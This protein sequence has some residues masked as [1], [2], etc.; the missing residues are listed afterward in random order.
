MDTEDIDNLFRAGLGDHASP[1][2]G[3]L[4]ARLQAKTAADAATQPQAAASAAVPALPDD[5]FRRKLTAH[6]TPPRRELWERLEDEHLRPRKR[7]EPAAAWWPMAIAAAVALLLV[8]GGA[9]W[10]RPSR[11]GGQPNGVATVRGPP[12]GQQTSRQPSLR[13]VLIRLLK[14]QPVSIR[15]LKLRQQL[16]SKRTKQLLQTRP[17]PARKQLQWLFQL[18]LLPLRQ[19]AN[20]GLHLPR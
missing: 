5:L 16:A 4:W 19:P 11:L 12:C 1:P 7:R 20:A 13:L 6:A 15:R 14:W 17:L 8:A 10:W 18:I 3:D 2:S 9:A